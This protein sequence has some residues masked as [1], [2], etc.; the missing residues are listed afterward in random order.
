MKAGKYGKVIRSFSLPLTG[1]DNGEKLHEGVDDQRGR[2]E[3]GELFEGDRHERRGLRAERLVEAGDVRVKDSRKPD[4]GV[5][6]EVRDAK[7]RDV[8]S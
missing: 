8:R 3:D 1:C 6:A 5:V 7:R 2:P 4:R